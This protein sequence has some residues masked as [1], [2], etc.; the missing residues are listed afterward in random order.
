MLLGPVSPRL[1]RPASDQQ[2]AAPD[3]WTFLQDSSSE[4]GVVL[5]GFGSTGLFGH[6]LDHTD[7][8]ELAAGFSA[9][10]PTRVLW[11][12]IPSNLPEGTTLEQL[13]LAENVKVVP[14]IDYN[15]VLGE[16]LKK[17]ERGKGLLLVG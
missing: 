1:P 4:A 15:D 5:V 3:V 16:G 8:V 10:A 14:W 2:A 12:L 11:P 6:S 7:F 9:L 17:P 13:P